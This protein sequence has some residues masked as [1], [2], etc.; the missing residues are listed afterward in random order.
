MDRRNRQTSAHRCA[1]LAIRGLAFAALLAALG[2]SGNGG[3]GLLADKT[4]PYVGCHGDEI[5][6]SDSA[7]VGDVTTW[8]ATCQGRWYRCSHT[9]H[10]VTECTDTSPGGGAP[11]LRA[12][13]DDT[14]KIA[15]TVP[16]AGAG[17]FDFGAEIAAASRLC[18]AAGKAWKELAA[19][20]YEC[21]A[22]PADVGFAAVAGVEA[23]E[24][25]ICGVRILAEGVPGG[26]QMV[27]RYTEA[28]AA[29][30]KKYGG[31]YAGSSK[32]M[33]GACLG[34][35]LGA[36]FLDGRASASTTWTWPGGQT[37]QLSVGKGSTP[38]APAALRMIYRARASVG[39][40]QPRLDN[41]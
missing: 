9:R 20:R 16:P 36:C 2:C 23:C 3:G 24:G 6:T 29:F 37:L 35:A 33:D 27:A 13:E 22:P 41:L 17:G 5:T 10:D 12:P 28:R 15:A 30:A 34:D 32:G 18:A 40:G 7:K 31:V 26:A 38:G 4:A 39:A 11:Q 1:D 25:K 8:T 14:P 19:D 21:S